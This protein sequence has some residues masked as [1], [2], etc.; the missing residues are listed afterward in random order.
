MA[1]DGTRS[2]A[3]PSPPVDEP[4]PTAAAAAAAALPPRTMAA[5]AVAAARAAAF[6]KHSSTRIAMVRPLSTAGRPRA[7]PGLTLRCLGSPDRAGGATRRAGVGHAGCPGTDARLRGPVGHLGRQGAG[8]ARA[9]G[10]PQ[11]GR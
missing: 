2:V 9:C 7:P 6:G 5:A 10:L 1:G 8:H 11:G 3:P 4:A